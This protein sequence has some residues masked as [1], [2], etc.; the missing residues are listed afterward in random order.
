[1]TGFDM[2]AR[3]SAMVGSLLGFWA[4]LQTNRRAAGGLLLIAALIA[5]Y[6]LLSLDDATARL[7]S[8]GTREHLRLQHIVEIGQ[9]RDWPERVTSSARLRQALEARLWASE[10]EGVARADIQD[11]ISSIGREVGLP[12]LDIRIELTKPTALPAGLRQINATIT[13]QPVEEAVTAMLERIERAPHL[14][15]VDRLNLKQQPAPF[16]EMVL[17]AYAKIGDGQGLAGSPAK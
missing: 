8:V 11:W 3:R 5:G 10:S 14:V 15:V 6:G 17:V 1:M 4:E 12:M 16:L 2:P 13:A 9:E 7:R